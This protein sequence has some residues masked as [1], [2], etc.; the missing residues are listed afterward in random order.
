MS[1]QQLFLWQRKFWFIVTAGVYSGNR[2]TIVLHKSMN[3]DQGSAVIAILA[4][5][6]CMTFLRLCLS[7]AM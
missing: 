4:F 7:A 3:S 1:Q 6:V 2:W 5:L